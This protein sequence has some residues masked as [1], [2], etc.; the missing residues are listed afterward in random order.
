MQ[1]PHEKKNL[2]NGGCNEIIN[3]KFLYL[4][5]DGRLDSIS[6]ALTCE[7]NG[8]GSLLAVG[9]NN[10]RLVVSDLIAKIIAAHVHP[11]SSVR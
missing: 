8:T 3:M 9:C 2:P 1:K 7:F 10:G 5:F 11:I 6:P 4:G